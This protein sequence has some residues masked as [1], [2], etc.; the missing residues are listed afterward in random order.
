VDNWLRRHT[1]SN[2]AVTASAG[3]VVAL[4]TVI[5]AAS[6]AS[7]I[8]SGPLAGFVPTGIRMALTTAVVAGLIV[9]LTSSCRVAIAI[10]QDRIAPILG[11]LATSVVANMGSATPEQMGLAVVSSVT[12]VTMITGLFL[13]ALGR[14]RL[15]NLI[16]YIP[17]PVIGGFLA[18]S[19]WLLVLG[20]IRVATGHAVKLAGLGQLFE[21]R[22]LLHWAPAVLFGLA[23][24]L[25]LRRAK[26]QYF[27]PMLLPVAIGLFYLGAWAA[28]MSPGQA[29]SE[30]W[31]P[32][33][34]GVDGTR[35][36]TAIVALKSVSWGLLANN[37]STLATILVTSLVSILLTATALELSV[38]RDIDLNRELSAA[39]AASF[40][41]GLGGGMVGFHSLSLS[42]L[43]LSMG[44]QSR[45]VGV[46][47]ALACAEVFWMGPAFVS[48]VP[49]FVCGGLLIF[50]GLIFLWE[51]V[52]E[53]SRKLTRLDYFVVVFILAVVGAVGY[54]QGVATGVIAAVV[55]FVHNYSRVDVVSH[56]MSGAD[57]RSNVDRPV[58]E[59]K[60]LREH[61]EQ[62]HVLH[63]QG[64]IFFGTANDL[65]R[66]VRERTEQTG[67]VPL[68]Y[69]VMDFRRVTGIDSSAVFSLCKVHQLACRLGFTLVMTQVEKGL[70]KQ[71][72]I[73]GLH[74]RDSASFRLFPDLDH[75]MEWCE[76]S[77]LQSCN[78]E[79]NG[80]HSH[81]TEQLDGIWPRDVPADRLLA[82]LEPSR[83]GKGTHLIRQRDP[84]ESLYFIESGRVTA[85]L[86]LANGKS[87]RL[88][89]MGP[90]TVVGEVGM[91][92]GG[93]RM[94]SVVTE[95]DCAVYRLTSQALDRMRDEDPPLALAFH[96]FLVRLLAE[97]L[98]TTS[99]MLRS[100]QENG[101]K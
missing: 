75:G 71:L 81:L 61:G 14:L 57:L 22:E 91:F 38:G 101:R 31:L 96:Q 66:D 47:A 35:L 10:P 82:Y 4:F 94:A 74:P 3:L 52:Y 69:V 97:R 84:S 54:T 95:D 51:W 42:R 13:L 62:I 17:Y 55:L 87:I 79:Q 80:N 72:A 39:G 89:S 9:A 43:A 53:A 44:A 8:F 23:L 29:R 78:H 58:R 60:C 40:V 50:L 7:L 2:A 99:N 100:F 70:R 64:F 90:G 27:I 6:F 26:K 19:G 21:G 16:R 36:I 93:Q 45:W 76:Q 48:F 24:F 34:S 28:G 41:S 73:G 77:L 63:L 18:G 56:A 86:E 5:A 65:L 20:G 33:F 88:R 85:R 11:L 67:R 83:V 68:K 98:T 59:L 37:L 15:G 32:S 49:R 92:L 12:L 30:G 25:V 46:V 1:F